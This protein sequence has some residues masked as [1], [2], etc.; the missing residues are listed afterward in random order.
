MKLGRFLFLAAAASGAA[1][2]ACRRWLLRASRSDHFDGRRF[3][4]PSATPHGFGA[5]LRWV[6]TRRRHPW[7]A[8]I[9]SVEGARPA[10]HVR[11]DELLVTLVGHSTTLL[12]TGGINLLTDPVW[13]ERVSPVSWAGPRRRR[14]PGI[15]FQ[16][17]PPIDAILVSHNHY[18]H[19]DVPTL[20]RFPSATPIFCGLGVGRIL[21]RIGFTDVR[22]MDWWDASE[23]EGHV[24]TA[25]PAQHFS[26]RSLCDRDATLWCGFAV[27][28]PAGAIYF[29]GDTGL[30]PHF[31]KISRRFASIRLALLP[32][33][34]Y[35]PRWFMC[36]VHLSPN[37]AIA[38]HRALGARRSIPIHHS[39]FALGDDG[40]TEA[41]DLLGALVDGEQLGGEIVIPPFGDA[42]AVPRFERS[43][44]TL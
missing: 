11:G 34:A 1:A 12:Q 9:E 4:N 27:D 25:V 32:I 42:V 36:P 28:T 44:R 18:D 6:A 40:A 10:E 15:G 23:V 38:A 29:A 30:G 19:L 14:A 26:S 13:S 33:G 39:T 22:E 16:A 41:V 3:H 8:W 43:G 31:E 5:F 20:R 21:R 2:I 24:I 35:L 37:D 7:P 17:L